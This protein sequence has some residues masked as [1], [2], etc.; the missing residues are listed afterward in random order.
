MMSLEGMVV[1]DLGRRYPA[2]LTAMYLG[3]YGAEVIKVDAPGSSPPIPTG[4]SEERYAAFNPADRNKRSIVLDLKKEAGRE[5][6]RRLVQRADVL[7]EGFRPG[8]MDRLGV[9]F[10]SLSEIN[11]ALIY[12]A[13][14][15]FG[16]DGPYSQMAGHDPTYNAIAGTLSLIGERGRRPVLTSYLIGDWGAAMHGV[17]GVTLALL[18][19]SRT[20]KGQFVDVAYLDSI[21]SALCQ[22]AA[23]YFMT[24]NVPKRG[25]TFDTGQ[26][27][28]AQVFE[29]KDGEYFVEAAV[30]P[31][32]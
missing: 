9:G 1:L 20:G 13:L 32:L 17:I 30:E 10:S 24:G 22:Q 8:V 7:I 18:A 4:T 25:E 3:D 28:F 14:S 29:C 12:L 23:G 11:P 16:Q 21:T 19:R 26:A 6:L 2:S 5:V 31:N 27:A 15:G